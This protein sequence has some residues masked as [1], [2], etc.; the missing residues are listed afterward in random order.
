M[1]AIDCWHNNEFKLQSVSEVF[2]FPLF[3]CWFTQ[4][5][6]DQQWKVE[7]EGRTT[8]YTPSKK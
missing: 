6:F 3:Q 8:I 2:L 5:F 7:E 4:L 1:Q